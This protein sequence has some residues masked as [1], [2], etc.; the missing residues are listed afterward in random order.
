MKI[1]TLLTEDS[2]FSHN[3]TSVKVKTENK[4]NEP[5]V[6]K[7]EVS[8]KN[9]ASD[10]LPHD[11]TASKDHQTIHDPVKTE[12][13]EGTSTSKCDVSLK[14]LPDKDSLLNN[15]QI[16]T[17]STPNKKIFTSY[18]SQVWCYDKIQTGEQL[19]KCDVC[20]KAFGD[21]STLLIHQKIHQA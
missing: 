18:K 2:V 20:K 17:G 3:L 8:L 13:S 5:T 16:H 9:E 6:F 1:S 7:S 11:Y 12:K 15:V 4:C 19:Y 10:V 14:V 21:R